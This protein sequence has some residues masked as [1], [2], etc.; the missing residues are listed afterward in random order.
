MAAPWIGAH[1]NNSFIISRAC[2][3]ICEARTR[4]TWPS[5][6]DSRLDAYS[7]LQRFDVP[8]AAAT[9]VTPAGSTL[10]DANGTTGF[11][12]C[13]S[14]TRAEKIC[15]RAHRL[16][17]SMAHVIDSSSR[18]IRADANSL[19]RGVDSLLRLKEFLA[20]REQRI[21]M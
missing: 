19:L 20:L 11:S 9:A 5:S 12:E 15:R 21:A 1:L 2:L 18:A 10:I 6:K 4:T 16:N 7:L 13:P 14:P 17:R 3:T 8:V